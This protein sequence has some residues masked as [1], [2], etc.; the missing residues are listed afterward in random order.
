MAKPMRFEICYQVVMP[1]IRDPW[2]CQSTPSGVLVIPYVGGQSV[3]FLNGSWRICLH[4]LRPFMEE[5]LTPEKKALHAS[6]QRKIFFL[7][8][9]WWTFW[10][11]LVKCFHTVWPLAFFIYQRWLVDK[12]TKICS[13]IWVSESGITLANFIFFIWFRNT[14]IILD[15]TQQDWGH[16]HIQRYGDHWDFNGNL[17]TAHVGLKHQAPPLPLRLTGLRTFHH[18]AGCCEAESE[19]RKLS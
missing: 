2:L 6:R 18:T 8:I 16:D 1:S 14:W 10:W 3:I 11:R 4:H 5:Q 13:M 19:S 12:G 15:T 17:A 7:G 9:K